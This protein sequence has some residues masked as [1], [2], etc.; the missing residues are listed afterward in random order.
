MYP[1]EQYLKTLKGYVR[2]RAQSVGYIINQALGF[3][4]EY[5]QKC[6]LTARHV[7]DDEEDPRMNDEFL[8]GK[9][10]W[11]ILTV[12][13]E[14]WIHDFVLNNAE[15]LQDYREYALHYHTSSTIVRVKRST[16][17]SRIF[18]QND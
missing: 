13:L 16:M 14:Q 1:V 2:Q 12:E 6:P 3:C 9:G 4:M 10:R 7:W 17:C 15:I 5:M 11:R 18:R 8:E